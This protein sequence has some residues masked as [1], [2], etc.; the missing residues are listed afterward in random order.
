MGEPVR[1]MARNLEA[2]VAAIV[3]RGGSEE[4]EAEMVAASLVDANLTGHDSH[5]VGMIPRYVESLQ[6]GGL[7]PNRH[8]SVALDSGPLLQLNGNQG[9]GQVVGHEAMAIAIERARRFG[10]AVAGLANAHHLGRIGRYS[11]QCVAAGLVSIH[12][13]NVLSRPI[14]APWG[15]R[16]ARFST[17][18]FCAGIPRAGREPLLLDF[19]TSRVAAGKCRIAYNKGEP[20]AAGTLIDDKGDPTTDPRY[21][22]LRPFG[23]LLPFG[24]H[25]GYGL[26]MVCEILGGA[27]AGGAAWHGLD[28]GRRRIVNGMLTLLIEPARLG[29][30]DRFV[31]ETEAFIEWVVRSPA[32]EGFDR[33]R[34]AGDPERESRARRLA[35][36]IPIDAATWSEILGAAAKLGIERDEIARLAGLPA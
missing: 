10:C 17:N 18:P 14:V 27:L 13:V 30:A 11:E 25:K 26:A 9:Y 8:V 28:D 16:D 29:D 32:A 12:F 21:A 24:E 33:V 19:A 35:E 20:L 7:S 36:G 2:A 23:A 1:V 5:G 31:R 6:E 34:I 3:A 22:M 4:R 15:G